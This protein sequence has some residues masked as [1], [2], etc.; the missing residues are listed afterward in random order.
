VEQARVRSKGTARAVSLFAAL[1]LAASA[2]VIDDGGE[3]EAV[4]RRG[5]LRHLGAFPEFFAEPF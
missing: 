1:S 4:R 3:L 5:V 2:R